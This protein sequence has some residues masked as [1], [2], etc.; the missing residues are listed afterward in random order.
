[1]DRTDATKLHALLGL[2][3]ADSLGGGARP[4]GGDRLV[5]IIKQIGGHLPEEGTEGGVIWRARRALLDR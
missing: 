2:R 4:S 5:S 3:R 1:M